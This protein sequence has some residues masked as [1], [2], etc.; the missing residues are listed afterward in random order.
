MLQIFHQGCW[1]G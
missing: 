1:R